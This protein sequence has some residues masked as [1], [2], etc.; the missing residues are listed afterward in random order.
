VLISNST[1]CPLFGKFAADACCEVGIALIVSSS[2]I[3]YLRI[4]QDGTRSCIY[5]IPNWKPSNSRQLNIY[6]FFSV[7]KDPIYK[8]SPEQ[9][10]GASGTFCSTFYT[11]LSHMEYTYPHVTSIC[12]ISGNMIYQTYVCSSEV[13]ASTHAH[14]RTSRRP[15]SS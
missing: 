15:T 14:R 5:A 11:D 8:Q 2:R 4:I 6:S 9:I 13:R 10:C 1:D 3:Y 7:Q 12:Q